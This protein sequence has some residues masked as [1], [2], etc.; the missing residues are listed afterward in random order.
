MIEDSGSTDPA[1]PPT[2]NAILEIIKTG[3][4]GASEDNS[5]N[6]ET[7]LA[8]Q[9]GAVVPDNGVTTHEIE[10]PG[11]ILVDNN[12]EKHLIGFDGDADVL[13]LRVRGWARCSESANNEFRKRI[14]SHKN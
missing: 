3:R 4:N 6:R 2:D 5:G 11:L 8:D 10:R 9:G 13:T 1:C 14:C 12:N 7:I